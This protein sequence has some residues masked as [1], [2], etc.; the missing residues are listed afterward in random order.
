MNDVNEAP[1]LADVQ[2]NVTENAADGTIVTTIAGTDPDG[3]DLSYSIIAGNAA[4]HFAIN[5]QTGAITVTGP[6]TTRPTIPIPSRSRLRWKPNH[7]SDP[8]NHRHQ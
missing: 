5:Q 3:D 7:R 6:S 2:A 8:H 4:G 1:D